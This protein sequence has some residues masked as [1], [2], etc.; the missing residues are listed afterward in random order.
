MLVLLLTASP[1]A[2]ILVQ[3]FLQDARPD[4]VWV[5]WESDT[6]GIATVDFGT[7]ESMGSAAMAEH[8]ASPHGTWVHS[9]LLT[10]LDPDTPYFYRVHTDDASSDTH[11]LRTPPLTGDDTQFRLVAMSD[12]QRDTSRPDM[13]REVVEDGV[14]AWVQQT[15]GPV[16]SDEL[17]MVLIPGDL[18]DNGWNYN[19]WAD[20][21]FDPAARLL[22]EVPSYPVYGNHEA[23][24]TNFQRYF[25]LPE[26]DS[27][28]V[29][30]EHWWHT[31]YAN[32][33]VIG[34]DSNPGF[35]NDEQLQWLSDLLDDTCLDPAIDFVFA[36]LHHP[37]LSEL[38]IDGNTPFTGEVIDIMEM[39]STRCGKP[40]VHFFG[41]THGYSR[42]QSQD[43]RHL[44][45]NVASAGG[46]IDRWAA[47][48]Q[49]DYPEFTVSQDEYG[50]VVVE[51]DGTGEPEFR[52]T[53]VSRGNADTPL[54][55]VV[56]DEIRITLNGI[57]PSTPVAL[58][59]RGPTDPTCDR[60]V[61]SAFEADEGFHA[62]SQWQLTTAD[63]DFTEPLLDRWQQH[64]NQYFGSDLNEGITLDDTTLPLDGL[65]DG[66]WRV[67]Y[68]HDGLMWSPWSEPARFEIVADGPCTNPP[69]DEEPEPARCGCQSHRGTGALVLLLLPLFSRRRST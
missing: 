25:H 7:T 53:R 44:W 52:L 46:A 58:G 3:P 33:R 51:V 20:T 60:L 22:A 69:A 14:L 55:N 2:E 18:V 63:C 67:R 30:A 42:G 5:V 68:R 62:A 61:A 15:Y 41:H 13:F 50:F 36:E 64:E 49:T 54:D 65:T 6:D 12:M 16:L 45:V 4:S 59:P 35:A 43:H 27:E 9:A 57:S 17:S 48:E 23:A 40:S 10:G 24:S 38:W 29:F 1:A 11:R 26:T 37:Y 66:C 47:F 32:L 8:E 34:L 39:F 21:F 56:R 19:E 31:D 28:P